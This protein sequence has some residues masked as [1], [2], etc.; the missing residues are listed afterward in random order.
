MFSWSSG[1]VLQRGMRG[2]MQ[3]SKANCEIYLLLPCPSTVLPRDSP[4][5]TVNNWNP[6][7]GTI[8][9]GFLLPAKAF[10]DQAILA[11]RSRLGAQDLSESWLLFSLCRP[12]G[13]RCVR[14]SERPKL[15]HSR[16]FLYILSFP[17][18]KI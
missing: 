5:A 17:T 9:Q 14:L 10:G 6:P 1:V 4:P 13:V 12:V 2:M 18:R 3:Q 7:K 11:R 8:L 15:T 16:G